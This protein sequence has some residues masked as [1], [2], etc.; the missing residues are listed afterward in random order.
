MKAIGDLSL[1]E[2]NDIVKSVETVQNY[3]YNDSKIN[4]CFYKNEIVKKASNLKIRAINAMIRK[5]S[6]LEDD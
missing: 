6:D 1:G 5:I 2:L 4:S 3:L